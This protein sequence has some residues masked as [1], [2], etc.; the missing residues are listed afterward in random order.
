M[1]ATWKEYNINNIGEQSIT[2]QFREKFLTLNMR[3]D[4]E[5][6]ENSTWKSKM[7]LNSILV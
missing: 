3:K 5:I 6:K 2:I 4:R 7:T 1:V